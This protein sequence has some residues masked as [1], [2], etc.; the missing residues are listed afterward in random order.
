MA[1]RADIRVGGAVGMLTVAHVRDQKAKVNAT[2][3]PTSNTEPAMIACG[4]RVRNTECRIGF[5]MKRYVAAARSSANATRVS[6]IAT[7][8]AKVV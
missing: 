2:Q 5:S 1:L 6:F 4:F 8:D 7:E 3:V